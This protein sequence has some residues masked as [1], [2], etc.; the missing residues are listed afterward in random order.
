M[1]RR[2]VFLMTVLVSMTAEAQTGVSNR[3]LDYFQRYSGLAMEEMSRSGVPAS[4]TLAQGALESGDGMSRLAVQ[5]NNHFGIKCHDDWSGKTIKHD[6][7]RNN[8]CFRKYKSV[9]ESFRDHSDFLNEKS[10]YAS[11]FALDP[12]DY[13]GWA[14]GLKKA[15]YA[16]SAG[17]DNALIR[18]IEEYNLQQYDLLALNGMNFRPG[19]EG[20]LA[21]VSSHDIRENNRV[22]YVVAK[23]GE[24]FQSLASEMEK[25]E[26]ELPRYNDLTPYDSLSEGQVIYVQPKRNKAEAG[27]KT[28]VVKAGESMYDIS[29]LY[30]VKLDRLYEMNRIPYGT[31][32]KAGAI[33][34][35]R[36]S[37]RTG[38][39]VPVVSEPVRESGDDGDAEFIIDLGL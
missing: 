37:V 19:S 6:D 16:T 38:T 3:R 9:E 23:A 24:T 20:F 31:E 4:I 39:V 29:Q 10:R 22:K 2:L 18:I 12:I 17:Y 27:K 26:W 1:K 30:A 32:P 28:H 7:D 14:K 15:G 21:S 33:L 5:A 11:L 36:K 8:E 13:K 25:L 35:L 34:Q